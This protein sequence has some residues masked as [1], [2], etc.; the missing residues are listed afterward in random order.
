MEDIYDENID[1]HSSRHNSYNVR[2][3][4]AETVDSHITLSVDETKEVE[5]VLAKRINKRNRRIEYKVKWKGYP[6]ENSEWIKYEE[7]D[8]RSLVKEFE[9]NLEK[10]KR[11]DQRVNKTYHHIGKKNLELFL[12]TAENYVPVK[13]KNKIVKTKKRVLMDLT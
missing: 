4:N 13:K 10:S 11:I 6:I 5:C 7:F 9:K 12:N 3:S 2:R 1:D 8:D